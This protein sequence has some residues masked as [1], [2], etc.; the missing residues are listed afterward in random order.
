MPYQLNE[1]LIQSIQAIG[2]A[3]LIRKTT[4]IYS[5]QIAIE[6]CNKIRQSYVI[7]VERLADQIKK[8][9]K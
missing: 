9:M 8:R 2:R 5:E 4:H 1:K 7:A 3:Y 6:I